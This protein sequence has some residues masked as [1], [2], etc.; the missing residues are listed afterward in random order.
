MI[1]T[2]RVS[3]RA[4]VVVGTAL[5]IATAA[6]GAIVTAGALATTPSGVTAETFRGTL[7]VLHGLAKYPRR[8]TADLNRKRREKIASPPGIHCLTRG[9]EQDGSNQRRECERET[10]RAWSRPVLVIASRPGELPAARIPLPHE[11]AER[12]GVTAFDDGA[13]LEATMKAGRRRPPARG[14]RSP[15]G[16]AARSRPGPGSRRGVSSRPL[17]G[18]DLGLGLR[19]RRCLAL[20]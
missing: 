5:V 14:G 11:P 15:H 2:S 17:A 4:M 7:R 13:R 3:T 9:T 16:G 10:G 20:L 18:R 19:R 6:V 12:L 8:V 1:R